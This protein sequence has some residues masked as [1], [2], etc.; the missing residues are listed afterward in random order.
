MVVACGVKS[1]PVL[2][3][4]LDAGELKLAGSNRRPMVGAAGKHSI[5]TAAAVR[6]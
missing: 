5:S 6:A 4:A 2:K 1:R 3:A